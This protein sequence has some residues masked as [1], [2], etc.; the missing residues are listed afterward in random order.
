MESGGMME[1]RIRTRPI[2]I[3]RIDGFLRLAALAGIEGEGATTG[4]A[5][6]PRGAPQFAQKAELVSRA[7]PQVAK[8]CFVDPWYLPPSI[9]GIT[10]MNQITAPTYRTAADRV[11]AGRALEYNDEHHLLARNP[12]DGRGSERSTDEYAS[13]IAATL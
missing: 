10:F 12:V 2:R 9:K 11:T 1:Y 4:A 3:R 7:C 5:T 13:L 6:H 8:N